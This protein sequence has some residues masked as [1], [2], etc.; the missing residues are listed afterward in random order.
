LPSAQG[1]P[2]GPNLVYLLAVT[3]ADAERLIYLAEFEKMYF[4][5]VPKGAPT[6]DTPGAGP[7]PALQ[8][9]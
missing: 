5:L 4:D 7:G 6:V 9:T 1:Q 3:P 8:A 2:S